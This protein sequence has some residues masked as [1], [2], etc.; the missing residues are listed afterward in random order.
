[1]EHLRQQEVGLRQR[2]ADLRQHET[3]LQLHQ[4]HLREQ[5]AHL[6]EQA[7]CVRYAQA[8]RDFSGALEDLVRAGRLEPHAR[9]EALAA[10]AGQAA[11]FQTE[12]RFSAGL[13]RRLL[14]A[15]GPLPQGE[16]GAAATLRDLAGADGP[17]ELDELQRAVGR[18]TATGRYSVAEAQ[19]HL[20]ATDKRLAARWMQAVNQTLPPEVQS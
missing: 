15:S 9:D 6:L 17:L 4:S 8:R 5:E 2:E 11:E 19:A 14:Q 18:L 13:V 20:L 16:S 3:Q 1:V 10:I 7:R 12:L